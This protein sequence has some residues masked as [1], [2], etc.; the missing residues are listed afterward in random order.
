VTEFVK[1][2]KSLGVTDNGLYEKTDD[3]VFS[4]DIHLIV[5]LRLVA[6]RY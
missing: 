3:W 5:P 4:M 6:W 1:L 2:V